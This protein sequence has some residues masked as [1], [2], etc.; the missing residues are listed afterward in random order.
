[1]VSAT[2]ETMSPSTEFL[3]SVTIGELEANY[4][5]YCKALRLL[6]REGRSLKKIQRTVC[7]HR[8]ELLHQCLPGRYKD[9]DYLHLK[10]RRETSEAG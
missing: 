5:L 4:F 6:I 9:P 3:T 8:L 1:M 10:L 2:I 7:W